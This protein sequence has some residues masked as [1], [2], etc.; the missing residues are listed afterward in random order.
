MLY[1]YFRFPNNE[2]IREKWFDFVRENNLLTNKITK[3]SVVCSSHFDT[4]NFINYKR[5]RLLEKEAVPYIKISRAT[6]VSYLSLLLNNKI[7]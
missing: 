6:Y 1:V 4:K 2:R 3:Y 5:T 7:H